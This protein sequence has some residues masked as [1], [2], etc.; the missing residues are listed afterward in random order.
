MDF[1]LQDIQLSHPYEIKIQ[2]FNRRQEAKNG[3]DWEWWFISNGLGIGFRVQAKKI[4]MENNLYPDVDRTNKYGRQVDLL[5][6][7]AENAVPPRI[8]L[9]VFYNYVDTSKVNLP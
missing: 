7:G 2:K 6:D 4:S 3:A 8:P 5:I 1:N 9:Y